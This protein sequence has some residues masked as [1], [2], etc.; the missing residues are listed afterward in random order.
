MLFLVAERPRWP[1]WVSMFGLS[2]GM[3]YVI[4]MPVSKYLA[5]AVVVT[6]AVAM[7]V[8][9]GLDHARQARDKQSKP[10]L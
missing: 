4:R 1:A 8:I 6:Y 2:L 10:T 3:L 7:G 9:E 5:V